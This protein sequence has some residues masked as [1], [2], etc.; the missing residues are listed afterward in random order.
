MASRFL[1]LVGSLPLEEQKLWL[2]N[3]LAHDPDSWTAPHLLN[4]KT[5]YDVLVNEHDCKGQEMYTVEDH[6]PSP[7]ESL[8]LPS[9]D[10]IYKVHV[11]NQELPRPGDSRPVMPPS[12]SVLSKH[13]TK[14]GNRGKQTCESRT[15]QGCFSNWLFTRNKLLRQQVLKTLTP[16]PWPIMII[17]PFYPLKC[18]HLN[19]VTLRRALSIGKTLGISQPYQ[20]SYKRRSVPSFTL[21]G[22]VLLYSRCANSGTNWTFSAVLL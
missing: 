12:Q 8:L 10:S 2:S 16:A 5:G 13:M 6:P 4:L 15:T 20:T 1:Q 3:Q 17:R 19:Q 7:N 21:G 9:L 14:S 18:T 11:R 22:L